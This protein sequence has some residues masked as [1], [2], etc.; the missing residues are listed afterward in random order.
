MSEFHRCGDE[1]KARRGARIDPFLLVVTPG[2]LYAFVPAAAD[3][4]RR[5]REAHAPV[6]A[7]RHPM[8]AE[9]PEHLVLSLCP[10]RPRNVQHPSPLPRE[11]HGLD[12]PVGVGHTFDDTITLQKV[13]ANA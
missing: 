5:Q 4:S 6:G 8:P 9:L 11:P 1:S 3:A 12:A 10:E 2:A 13:E 7:G